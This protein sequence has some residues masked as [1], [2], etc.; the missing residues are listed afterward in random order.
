MKP[1]V[2]RIRPFRIPLFWERK[3][4]R[5]LIG[6]YW[7]GEQIISTAKGT[8]SVKRRMNCTGKPGQFDNKNRMYDRRLHAALESEDYTYRG[9]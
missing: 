6:Y 7:P 3:G 8:E 5:K 9:D 1:V 4:D 2:N